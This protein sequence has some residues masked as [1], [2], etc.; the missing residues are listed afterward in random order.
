MDEYPRVTVEKQ[1]LRS[2]TARVRFVVESDSKHSVRLNRQEAEL[3]IPRLMH[4][5]SRAG[6]EP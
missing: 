1:G 5:L 6:L 2:G 3:L 4:S